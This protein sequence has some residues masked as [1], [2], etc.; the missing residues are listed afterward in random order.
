[1]L[2]TRSGR[3]GTVVLGGTR[4]LSG[5]MSALI[6]GN[7]QENSFVTVR[8]GTEAY[9]LVTDL[10]DEQR[11]ESEIEKL[12]EPDRRLPGMNLSP[13]EMAE[14]LTSD[15]PNKIRA[16][17]LKMSP[18]FRALAVKAMRESE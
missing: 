16:A 15:D 18:E 2:T 11:G 1:M 8:A 10:P 13:A 7:N 5:E 14:I 6:R 4:D 3:G 9:V 12:A 17:L